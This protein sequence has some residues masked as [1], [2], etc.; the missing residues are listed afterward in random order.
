MKIAKKVA[1]VRSQNQTRDH[2]C[3]WPGCGIQVP[4]AV[5]GCKEHWFKLP[6]VLRDQI[7]LTYSPGQEKTLSPSK[8][9]LKVADR[10][11]D[12]IKTLPPP[13]KPSKVLRPYQNEGFQ[14]FEGK[15]SAYLAMEMRLG[16]TL[17]IIRMLESRGFKR[18]IIV[19]PKT[20]L[21]SWEIELKDEGHLFLNISDM[22]NAKR[23]K[24]LRED[25]DDKYFLV[26]YEAFANRN[27]RQVVEDGDFDSIITDESTCISNHRS[28]A[29][30]SLVTLS[31]R[32]KFRACLSGTPTPEEWWQ[33]WSQMAFLNEGSWMGHSSF[34][35]WQY[36]FFKK[37]PLGYGWFLTPQSA[38]KI[39]EAFHVEAY[40]LTRKQAGIGEEKIYQ[41]RSGKLAGTQ[42]R[43]YRYIEDQWELPSDFQ[44]HA[45]Y[46]PEAGSTI[47]K[48]V[49]EIWARRV[50]GGTLPDG[51]PIHSWKYQELV[52][53]C[54]K[55]LPEEKIVVWFAFNDEMLRA[56]KDLAEA[57]IKAEIINGKTPIAQRR[58]TIARYR[59]GSLGH[60]LV[61]VACGRF[62]LDFSTSSTAIYFSNSY[63]N[64]ARLQS[65][66]RIVKV[67]KKEPLLY[68]DFIT[69]E[70][71]E[72]QLY[73]TLRH[74]KV[75]AI[76]FLKP[77]K[78]V[79]ER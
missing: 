5:W 64:L 40:C 22:P 43:I 39:K 68:I 46:D 52:E 56:R 63:S 65:E 54:S 33:I 31:R 79:G 72:V 78:V 9:Y 74:K 35:R 1:Y 21:I 3:H 58:D 24:I 10:V 49:V 28:K 2:T 34:Y 61:Q 70:T 48:P 17:L 32:V 60:V 11:Q 53:I 26:N 30:M 76:G 62:G 67:G 37:D 59:D 8:D 57:G 41:V 25:R 18:N 12:W 14:K 13:P 66:D 19:A 42:K 7:W 45:V 77:P 69:E 38:K 15:D 51:E 29:T 47:Y 50:C 73:E 75:D 44:K 4:P 71:L 55:E 27:V 36:E 6:K 23:A 16:K 20:V